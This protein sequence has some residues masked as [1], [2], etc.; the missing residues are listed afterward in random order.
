MDR[1]TIYKLSNENL[2]AGST[3]MGMQLPV[4][5]LGLKGKKSLSCI[6]VVLRASSTIP[7]ELTHKELNLVNF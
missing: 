3:S 4:K 6:F 2:V 1:A 7:E 5:L